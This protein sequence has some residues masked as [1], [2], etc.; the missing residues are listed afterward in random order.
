MSDVNRT[1]S[2]FGPPMVAINASTVGLV[3]SGAAQAITLPTPPDSG[4]QRDY[5]TQLDITNTS[6]VAI[7]IS[8]GQGT[9][10]APAAAFPTTTGGNFVVL[11]GNRRTLTVPA[12]VTNLSVIGTGAGTSA[13]YFTLGF[14]SN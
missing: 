8:F 5:P 6:T 2:A 9:N 1:A 3:P 11:P 14:G 7:A 12:N 13:A 10:T 4:G